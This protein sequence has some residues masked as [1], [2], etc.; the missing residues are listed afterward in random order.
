MKLAK[1]TLTQAE[2][3]TAL[4]RQQCEDPYWRLWLNPAANDLAVG[5]EIKEVSAF[6][7]FPPMR[8]QIPVFGSVMLIERKD[9]KPLT[10]VAFSCN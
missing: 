7:I 1:K 10:L 8:K 4:A 5:M 2:M 3:E 6:H 9:G